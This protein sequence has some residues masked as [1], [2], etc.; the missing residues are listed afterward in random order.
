VTYYGQ[1]VLY[2]N[3]GDGTFTDVA[4]KAGLLH[5]RSRW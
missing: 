2:P 5:P 3:N 1:N 4:E